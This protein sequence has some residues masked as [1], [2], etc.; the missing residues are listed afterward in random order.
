MLF[1]TAQ[2]DSSKRAQV[3]LWLVKLLRKTKLQIAE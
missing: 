2:K 1:N 3:K